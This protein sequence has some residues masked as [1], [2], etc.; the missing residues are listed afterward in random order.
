MWRVNYQTNLPQCMHCSSNKARP[1]HV[2]SRSHA[3]TAKTSNQQSTMQHSPLVLLQTPHDICMPAPPGL[4]QWLRKCA[5]R[6]TVFSA[7]R[8]SSQSPTCIAFYAFRLAN[9]PLTCPGLPTLSFD[10]QVHALHN[11]LES[12]NM[13]ISALMAC[14]CCA[15]E[16]AP[17]LSA[18]HAYINSISSVSRAVS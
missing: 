10:R 6:Q 12:L 18:L 8:S 3:L 1:L 17:S 7:Q 11:Q 4:R 13:L 2:T 14:A 15:S 9:A 5:V 16:L